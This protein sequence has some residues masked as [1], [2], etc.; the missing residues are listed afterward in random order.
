MTE[1]FEKR[2]MIRQ[3][4]FSSA[5]KERA[6]LKKLFSY[7]I[8]EIVYSFLSRLSQE[9]KFPIPRPFL[10]DPFV[11]GWTW[12]DS[13]LLTIVLHRF[14]PIFLYLNILTHFQICK[15]RK[16]RKLFFQILVMTVPFQ[17]QIFAMGSSF[18]FMANT[19]LSAISLVKPWQNDRTFALNMHW[20]NFQ[21]KMLRRFA[22]LSNL[23]Q[24][25]LAMLRAVQSILK[26]VKNFQW[27]RLTFFCL[28]M[29]R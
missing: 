23:V 1:R 25:C 5:I 17:M 2:W 20:T 3:N 15:Y 27:T 12:P 8:E 11:P 13:S 29:L 6:F 19:F 18:F 16:F 26:A 4:I 7:G 28:N 21:C 24:S 14:T 10:V 9:F 22:I